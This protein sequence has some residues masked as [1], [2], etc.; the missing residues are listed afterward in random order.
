MKKNSSR[1]IQFN[2]W[3][4][5]IHQEVIKTGAIGK[6]LLT[7]SRTNAHLK[8]TYEELGRLVEKGIDS[9]E[10]QWDCVKARAL[11]QTIKACK[12]DLDHLDYQVHKIKFS[13]EAKEPEAISYKKD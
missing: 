9:G 2:H 7:A 1:K 3:F 8:N 12:K 10:L 13:A 4:F 5:T 6:K 11:L